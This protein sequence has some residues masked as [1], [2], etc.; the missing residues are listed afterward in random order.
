MR[1]ETSP[2]PAPIAAQARALMRGARTAVLGTL[3]ADGGAPYGSL[4]LSATCPDATPLLLLSGLAAH[5]R[6]LTA[7][8]RASLLYDATAGLDDPLTGARLSLVGTI[9]PVPPDAAPV[10]RARFLA[11]FPASEAYAGFA[12]FGFYFFRP[13]RAHLVAGF[14]QIHWLEGEDILLPPSQ[15]AELAAAEAGILTHMNQ[16]HA[17][18]ISL[19][20]ER[21][22]GLAP[23]PWRMAGCDSEGCDLELAGKIARLPFANQI[24]SPDQARR[25]LVGLSHLARSKS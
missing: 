6:N 20:A 23:G 4:V 8:A 1:S 2:E 16:D 3:M 5:T 25:E 24:I 19:Y 17:D 22:L 11:R 7:D 18:S 9:A 12:D 10:C 21:L 14:G 15:Y 13:D